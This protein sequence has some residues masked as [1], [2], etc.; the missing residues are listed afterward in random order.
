M[1]QTYLDDPDY[2]QALL[3]LDKEF[4][5]IHKDDTS[6]DFFVPRKKRTAL[7]LQEICLLIF[8]IM[9]ACVIMTVFI[10]PLLVSVIAIPVLLF[11]VIT[12][13][14]FLLKDSYE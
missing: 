11:G 5:G 6:K 1:R 14:S 12:A 4:P 8:I 10:S 13:L 9:D 7:P 3:E 2:Q